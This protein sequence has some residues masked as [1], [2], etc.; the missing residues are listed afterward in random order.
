MTRGFRVL[1]SDSMSPKAAE[2]LR[3][4]EMIQVD[5]KPKITPDELVE[6][7]GAYR[8]LLVRSRTKVTAAVIARADHLDVIGRAGIGVDNIDV[9]AASKRGILV[10][11]APTGNLVTTA[12][13]AICLLLSLA[14]FIPQ[15]TASMKAGGW[16]KTAF[17]G[18]E[19]TGKTL[20]LV[21]MGN[22]GRVV[23]SRAHGLKMHVIAHDPFVTGEAAAKLGVELVSLDDLLA[24]ADA[25]SVHTPLTAETRGILGAAAF[26]KMKKGVMIVNAARG[27]VIDEEALK[28]ALDDGT[29]WGAAIDVFVK[30]PTPAGHPLVGHPRVICTPHLGAST[31]EAQE[32]VAIEVAEQM[33]DFVERG[34][35]R[36]AINAAAVAANAD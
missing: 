25:I 22:I 1:I 15:A 26:G 29:V 30:E 18:K 24:R 10:E 8:G 5:V 31:D 28:L 16:E 27:G 12:E 34:I 11:N 13:H 2:I 4:S 19:I 35:V 3:A 20:G 36:N 6:E 33:V 23:A 9:D 7:I 32:K 17:Q 21:G 14:R